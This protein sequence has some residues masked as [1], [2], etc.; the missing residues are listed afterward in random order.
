MITKQKIDQISYKSVHIFRLINTSSIYDI[1][2]VQ[3][4]HIL[5]HTNA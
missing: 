1:L 2:T 3:F 5:D 4:K